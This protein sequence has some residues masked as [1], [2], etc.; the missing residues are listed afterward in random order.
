MGTQIPMSLAD[1]LA[2]AP[3]HSRGNV[4]RMSFVLEQLNDDD[5]RALLAALAVPV[6]HPDRIS[7]TA[8]AEALGQEGYDVH[9]KT[10]ETHRKGACRCE[11]GT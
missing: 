3:R 1:R 11:P 4:C 7:N 5:R 2:D 10:V 8:I 6:G 9:S